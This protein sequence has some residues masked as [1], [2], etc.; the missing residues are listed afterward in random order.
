MAEKLT[1]RTI[2]SFKPF[3]AIVLSKK[4]VVSLDAY[5]L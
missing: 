3:L 4:S 5:V 1:E 2:D